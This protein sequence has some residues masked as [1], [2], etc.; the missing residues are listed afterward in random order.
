M[1]AQATYLGSLIAGAA[2]GAV[3][4]PAAHRRWPTLVSRYA[5]ASLEKRGL[6]AFVD[7]W[8]GA[9]LFGLLVASLG[10]P[11]ASLLSPF[12]LLLRDCA[13]PGQSPGKLIAGLVVVDLDS[14][15]PS[16]A[17][18]S[19]RRN[20]FFVVPGFNFV[21]MMFEAQAIQRDPQGMR[22][23]DRL[24]RTQVVEGKE[25]PELV[26]RLQSWLLNAWVEPGGEPSHDRHQC[27]SQSIGKA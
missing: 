10:F 3:F 20:V 6:A 17:L 18:R 26:K 2:L 14:G 27:Q 13:L 21:A 4:F 8:I 9:T 11:L 23:G 25:A 19:M 12:Y 16:G 7:A 22:L 15:A 1:D 24:A 5:K